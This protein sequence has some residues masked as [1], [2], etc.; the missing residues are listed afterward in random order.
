MGKERRGIATSVFL[1]VNETSADLINVLCG[2][3]YP[4]VP[5]ARYSCYSQLVLLP[6]SRD[7]FLLLK[8]FVSFRVSGM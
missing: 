8:D 6:L 4:E 7:K 3:Q 5:I 2:Q 1:L